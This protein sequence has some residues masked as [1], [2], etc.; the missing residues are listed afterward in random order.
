MQKVVT[1]YLKSWQ[2]EHL[3]TRRVAVALSGRWLA[4]DQHDWPLGGG[5][6]GYEI[7][8]WAIFVLE[9]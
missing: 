3:K 6:A 9:K 5:T 7:G 8:I 1:V 4:G 2:T